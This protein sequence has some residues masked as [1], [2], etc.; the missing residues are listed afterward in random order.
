[1][2]TC[3]DE[4]RTVIAKAYDSMASGGYIEFLDVHPKFIRV[5]GKVEGTV[6]EEWAHASYAAATKLNRDLTKPLKYKGWLEEAGFVDVVQ[7]YKPVPVGEWPKDPTQKEIGRLTLINMLRVVDIFK[8]LLLAGGMAKDEA[9]DLT[10][11]TQAAMREA[12]IIGYHEM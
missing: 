1:M 6:F 7:E 4:P 11:R 2:V 3:F 12:E 10:A 9:D 8:N 5:N